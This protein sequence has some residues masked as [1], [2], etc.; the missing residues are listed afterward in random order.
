MMLISF[1][2]LPCYINFNIFYIYFCLFN[3]S[4]SNYN[5]ILFQIN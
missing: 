5:E 3:F 1:W 4:V 2:I